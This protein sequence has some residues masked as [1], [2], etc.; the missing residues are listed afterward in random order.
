MSTVLQQIINGISIGSVYA[1]IAVGYSLVYSIL[2][3][4]NFAHGGVLMLGSYFGYFALTLFGM[5]FWV[6]LPLAIIGAGLLGV[7]NERLAYRPIRMRNSPLL[8]LMISSLGASIFLENF[9]IVTIGPTFRTYPEVFA[10]SPYMIGDLYIGRLDIIIFVIA[11]ISV[12]LLTWIIYGTRIGN[13]IRATS[14]NMRVASLMGINPDMIVAFVFFLAGASAGLGGVLFGIKYTVWPQMGILTLKAFI[15]AVVGGLGSLPGAVVG[16][17][18][19]G[20]TET[21][22]AAFVS[23]AFRDLFSYAL[24]IIIIIVRPGGLL[25]T[26][27][28]EKA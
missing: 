6:A 16:A 22:A 26:V 5:P 1:L 19:L 3:F 4:S 10:I 17:M 25:G 20:V 15:A 9:T 28:G 7:I 18:V 8:Y 23:S 12:A 27:T 14:Y 2:K 24:M 11:T 21:F 13:A